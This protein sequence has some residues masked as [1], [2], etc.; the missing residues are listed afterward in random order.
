MTTQMDLKTRLTY[1]LLED[2]PTQD[3]TTTTFIPESNTATATIIAK[4]TGIFFGQAVISEL[5]TL[6][7]PPIAVQFNTL[8]GQ[9]VAPGHLIVTLT[10]LTHTLLKIE[11]VLL[12]LIQHTSGIATLTTQF[13]R[14]LNDP[15]IE[16][17]DTRKTTP[18]WR[19]LEKQAVV[20]GGGHNHRHSLSDMILIKENHLAQLENNHQLHTFGA[21][22]AEH[23]RQ[24][25]D[26]K[27]EV[28]I[29]TL[30][31]LTQL[32][33][34]QVDYLLFD[35][36]ELADLKKAIQL[37]DTVARHAKREVSGNIT[38][39]TIANY[40]LIPIHRISIGQLTHSPKALDLSMRLLS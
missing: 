27:I 35:N 36:F 15:A 23:K 22:I 16:I 18:L 30:D 38:L 8:D 11:R 29:E 31:Q 17:L 34:S 39:D 14:A 40:H 13:V 24:H 26:L 21:I 20:A 37:C 5:C 6:V 25:P 10:G 2:C 7:S 4:E 3:I 32:D 12:N 28:E 19:D 9:A 1:A 33:L